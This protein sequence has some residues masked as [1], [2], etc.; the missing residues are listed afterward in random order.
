M[1]PPRARKLVKAKLGIRGLNSSF[2]VQEKE[3]EGETKKTA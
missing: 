3:N 1:F 2:S